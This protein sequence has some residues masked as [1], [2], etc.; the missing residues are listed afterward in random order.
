MFRSCEIMTL[1]RTGKSASIREIIMLL[2]ELSEG[3][4][5]RDTYLYL[6][7]H[8]RLSAAMQILDY[9]PVFCTILVMYCINCYRLSSNRATPCGLGPITVSFPCLTT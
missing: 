6:L 5:A 9:L 4:Y 2:R 7:P 1:K 3:W 8:L